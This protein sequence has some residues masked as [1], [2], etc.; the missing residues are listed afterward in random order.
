MGKVLPR[1]YAEN[2]GES[3]AFLGRIVRPDL[4]RAC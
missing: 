4:F 2:S 1:K 3:H